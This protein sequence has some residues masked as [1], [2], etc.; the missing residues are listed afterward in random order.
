MLSA[1]SRLHSPTLNELQSF[2][3]SYRQ[4]AWPPTIR[5]RP[6]APPSRRIARICARMPSGALILH[7]V[8]STSPE[9][10]AAALKPCRSHI[11]ATS[12]CDSPSDH[13]A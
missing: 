5:H 2:S 1:G 9:G 6:V 12:Y 3:M 11:I 7:E 10:M 13:E 8:S 4:E